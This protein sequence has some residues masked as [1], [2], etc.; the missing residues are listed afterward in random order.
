MSE[1]VLYFIYSTAVHSINIGV[2]WTL[3]TRTTRNLVFVHADLRQ[4]FHMV[5]I[6]SKIRNFRCTTRSVLC[7]SYSRFKAMHSMYQTLIHSTVCSRYIAVMFLWI[8]H[9]RKPTARPTFCLSNN[10]FSN[11]I[12]K[13]GTYELS[14]M[15]IIG[16]FNKRLLHQLNFKQ[17]ITKIAQR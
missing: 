14:N 8:T 1:R 7:L 3:C 13:Y 2:V 12:Y 11:K 6:R 17:L 15:T 16:S 10:I 9:N 5:S 4:F